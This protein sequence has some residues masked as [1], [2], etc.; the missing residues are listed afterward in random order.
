MALVGLMNTLKLE[1]EKYD[2]KV[3]TVAPIAATRLTADVLP[4]D[5]QEKM[6]PEFVAPLVLYLCS[7]DCPVS[8]KIYNAGMGFYNRAVVMT[9]PGVVMGNGKI[10]PSVEGVSASWKNVTGL[11]NARE[12]E[13]LNDFVSDVLQAFQPKKDTAEAAAGKG[14]TSVK[15]VFEKMPEVFNAKAASGVEVVFQFCISGEGGGNWY[16]E[17]RD[18]ACKVEAGNHAKPNCT[19][20]MD[21]ADFISMISGKLPSMQ[22]YTSGKLKIEGDIIKSQL[23]EKL[24]KF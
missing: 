24:F 8:G 1:G 23:I 19:I 3:N 15:A 21:G 5:L 9:A 11:K 22:A 6:T 20:K 4:A 17:I 13:Q 12:Y 10:V 18:A 2:I 14:G 16:A 7:E